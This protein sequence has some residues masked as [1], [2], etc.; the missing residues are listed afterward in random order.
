MQKNNLNETL[1]IYR[2]K[3]WDLPK[4][5]I[6]KGETIDQTALRG[7]NAY[8]LGRKRKRVQ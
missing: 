8:K 3:K 1:F 2:R 5:K 7:K 6:D 4:G